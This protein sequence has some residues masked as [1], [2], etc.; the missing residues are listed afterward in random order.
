[1]SDRSTR[2]ALIARRLTQPLALEDGKPPRI[3]RSTLYTISA[4]VM[5]SLLWAALTQVQELTVA[6]GQIIPR[7]QIETIQHLEGGIVADVDFSSCFIGGKDADCA[8]ATRKIEEV[9]NN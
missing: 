2:R 1:M 9:M 7:G 6:Q 3:L 8:E 5:A 4:F